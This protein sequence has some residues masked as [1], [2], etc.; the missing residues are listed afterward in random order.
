MRELKQDSIGGAP[1]VH[2]CVGLDHDHLD[3]QNLPSCFPAWTMP[4]L[5]LIGRVGSTMVTSDCPTAWPG[6]F[7]LTRARTPSPYKT[8]VRPR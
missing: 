2:L 1:E 8:K 6:T 7:D 4:P 5:A 3:N